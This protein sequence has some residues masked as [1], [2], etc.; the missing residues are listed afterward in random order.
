MKI[1]KCVGL[2]LKRAASTGD[3][4]AVAARKITDIVGLLSADERDAV[5]RRSGVFRARHAGFGSCLGSL[6]AE[7]ALTDEELDRNKLGV[8]VAG[9]TGHI[10][11]SW[12]FAERAMKAGAG[13]VNPAQFPH[14]LPSAVAVTISAMIDAHGPALAIGRQ[15]GTVAEALNI[16]EL[17]TFS[18]DITHCLVI[19]VSQ[20]D[21]PRLPS[22]EEAG[23]APQYPDGAIAVL[24]GE[25]DVGVSTSAKNRHDRGAIGNFTIP[26]DFGEAI[27]LWQKMNS[28]DRND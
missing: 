28:A 24:V 10:P 15:A 17:L 1:L 25:G 3:G 6:A 12:E 23:H 18:C 8:V 7:L 22:L 4:V 27:D 13:L 21:W 11:S 9:S 5:Q 20:S 14:L 2:D 19:S 16:A 26:V